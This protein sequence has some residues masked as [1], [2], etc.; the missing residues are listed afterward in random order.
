[1]V[2]FDSKLQKNERLL[3]SECLDT[4]DSDA[5]TIGFK[6]VIQMIEDNKKKTKEKTES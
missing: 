1:M 3:C 2:V 5:R 6:K 4:F